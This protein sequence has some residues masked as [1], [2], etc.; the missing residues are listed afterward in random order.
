MSTRFMN[1]FFRTCL[2]LLCLSAVANVNARPPNIVFILTDDLDYGIFKNLPRIDSMMV[3]KGLSFNNHFVSLSSCCPSR[4]A[5]LRGQFAHNNGVYTNKG[6]EGGFEKVYATGL[7]K[8][9][10]ATSL[11]N[12]G[13]VTGLFGKYLNGYPNKNPGV[14]YIP[15]GWTEWMVPNDGSPADQYNYSLNINGKTVKYGNSR[16][17]Y[18]VDVISA[19]AT[20][21]MQKTVEA[22][23]NQPFFVYMAPVVPHS[24]AIPPDRYLKEFK[25][26]KA[27][28]SPSFNEA[29][30]SDKPQWLAGKHLLRKGQIEK[31]DALYR[32]RRRTM[33]AVEDMVSDVFKTLQKIGQLDNTYIFFT[34]DNGYHMGEHRM[35][36]G[37]STGFEEDLRI[38]LVVVGPGVS[39]GSVVDKLTANV[40]YASTFAELAGIPP[41][42]FSDGRSL[43][44]FLKGRTVSNWRDALLLEHAADYGA[45]AQTFPWLE[46]LDPG[47]I[48]A[49]AMA[50][51][52]RTPFIGLRTIDNRTYIEYENG[53]REYYDL[54]SDPYQMVNIYATASPTEM[55]RLSEWV[56]RLSRA[57]GQTLRD[58]EIAPPLTLMRRNTAT[59]LD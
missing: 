37:K 5:T 10:F 59:R 3:Q 54:V 6:P 47:D 28:R 49:T 19:K 36:A 46:P 13:Y 20:Q 42:P 40:D 45:A 29:D 11:K 14:L 21:F 55:A 32:D 34:S 38:P 22:N 57:S 18:F 31:I 50:S 17:D 58:A 33:L 26:L 39:A 25:D 48:P 23:P 53:D 44:P 52:K 24:P 56:R 7:E 12:A 4:V 43:A 51:V 1:K 41:L 30:V 16:S 2:I 15:D 27:P 35:D 9:T 8:Q